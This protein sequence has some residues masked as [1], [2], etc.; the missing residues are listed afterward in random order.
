MATAHRIMYRSHP[1]PPVLHDVLPQIVLGASISLTPS[2]GGN[3]PVPQLH[4]LAATHR[5]IRSDYSLHITSWAKFCSNR[6]RIACSS[7]CMY[8]LAHLLPHPIV[9]Y[10]N[11]FLFRLPECPLHMGSYSLQGPGLPSCE[12]SREVFYFL[13]SKSCQ[14]GPNDATHF[15]QYS[16]APQGPQQLRHHH[17]N[18]SARFQIWP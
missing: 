14:M 12:G 4:N 10:N 6:L 8:Y 7:T 18:S 16:H 11:L 17:P 5:P 9:S 2:L 3:G 1:P 15:G 13:S